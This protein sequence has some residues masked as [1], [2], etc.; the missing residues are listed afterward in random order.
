MDVFGRS[1]QPLPPKFHHILSHRSFL[2]FLGGTSLV[3][4]SQNDFSNAPT[5]PQN[6][7]PIFTCVL[8][9]Y[10]LHYSGVDCSLAWISWGEA[11]PH[12]GMMSS[13]P[14]P[15]I[16]WVRREGQREGQIGA[17]M[18]GQIGKGGREGEGGNHVTMVE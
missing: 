6:A 14:I 8:Y 5:H 18:D 1:L 13:L 3:S 17:W 9:I 4:S 12:L 16:R 15:H 10:F 11:L 7:P 2:D